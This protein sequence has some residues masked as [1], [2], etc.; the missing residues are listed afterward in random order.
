MLIGS[1]RLNLCIT[2]VCTGEKVSGA[3]FFSG[4]E[5]TTIFGSMLSE[6]WL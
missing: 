6:I 5:N 3:F 2:A 1:T 4:L